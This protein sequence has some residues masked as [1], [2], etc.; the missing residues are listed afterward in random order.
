MKLVISHRNT[1]RKIDGPFD[2]CLTKED[3]RGL[4]S[5]LLGA[6][7][8]FEEDEK[9]GRAGFGYGWIHVRSE[10]APFLANTKPKGWDE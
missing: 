3:L 4:V 6:I 1:K 7:A 10:E 8:I 2:I 9:S 5:Q